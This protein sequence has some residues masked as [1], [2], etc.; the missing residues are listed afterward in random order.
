MLN[1]TKDHAIGFLVGLG[2]SAVGFYLYKK[3]QG[4]VEE[5]LRS[6]GIE[7]SGSQAVATSTWS[8]EELVREKEHLEDLIAEKEIMGKA[9]VPMT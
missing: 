5:F 7:V 3:N 1:L 2:L 9:E 8:L 4:K 6:Q